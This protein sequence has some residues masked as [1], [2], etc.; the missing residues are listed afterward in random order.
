MRLLVFLQ[1]TTLMHPGGAGRTRA[2]RVHQVR[3][4]ADPALREYG[5]YVPMRSHQVDRRPR[6]RRFDH[7]PDSL[8]ELAAFDAA[9]EGS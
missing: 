5:T 7:L 6:V 3:T 2:E 8:E 1:G 4:G 9:A